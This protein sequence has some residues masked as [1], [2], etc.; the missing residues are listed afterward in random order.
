MELALDNSTAMRLHG[1]APVD[2]RDGNTMWDATVG[3]V[4]TLWD[5]DL[6]NLGPLGINWISPGY[7]YDMDWSEVPDDGA[8]SSQYDQVERH[9]P[10]AVIT[11]IEY[12]DNEAGQH[13]QN[14]TPSSITRQSCDSA[15]TTQESRSTGGEYYVDGNG[16]RAPF[17]GRYHIRGSV[18]CSQPPL[19]GSETRPSTEAAPSL[20]SPKL[21][22]ENAYNKLIEGYT[23]ECAVVGSGA[24][25][26]LFPSHT[27]VEL[28]VQRYFDSFSPILPFLR[29]AAL[30]QESSTN[31]LLLLAVAVIG[32]R[33]DS[34]SHDSYIVLSR[35]LDAAIDRHDCYYVQELEHT[36]NDDM[37]VPG[38]RAELDNS[39]GLHLLQAGILNLV[40]LL[41]SGG[42]KLIEKASRMRQRLVDMC[43]S[44]RLLDQRPNR[45]VAPL[46]TTS[47]D[48]NDWLITEDKIR[49]G[50]VLW[51]R[52]AHLMRSGVADLSSSLTPQ[53][54][55][56]LGSIPC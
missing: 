47:S 55:T 43:I 46:L 3:D 18:L 8:V 50:M 45:T 37:Y 11:P 14:A 32:S 19:S 53:Q 30:T 23:R 1:I 16:P 38:R 4:V 51:V 22:S 13:N 40:C 5:I 29:P 24:S 34:A 17:G 35:A 54:C 44:M 9:A 21:C 10:R 15:Q 49:T 48:L 52:N 31:W 39:A 42:R 56:S 41:Q 7:P 36:H 6:P 27:Q 2:L 20:H 33:Y 26:T 12:L 25:P 28:Y